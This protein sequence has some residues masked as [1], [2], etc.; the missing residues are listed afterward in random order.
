MAKPTRDPSPILATQATTP[1]TADSY[2]SAPRQHA[3]ARNTQSCTQVQSITQEAIL[4]CIHVHNDVTNHPFTAN[5]ASHRQF[6]WEILN[7]VL[8]TNTGALMEM[9]HL[10][11]SPKYKELWGK[12]YVIELGHLAQGIPGISKGT[13]TIV[14]IGQD[15]VLIN[16]RKDITYGRVCVNYHPEKADPNCTCLTVGS[17]CI[18]YPRD[19]SAPTVDM[20]MVKIHLNSIVSTK[21]ARYCTINLK[22]F[23]LNTP[24][25]RPEF[26]RMKQAELPEEFAQIYK[27]HDLANASGFVLI[28]KSKSKKE[29]MASLKQAFLHLSSSKMP[30]QAWLSPKPHHTRPMATQFLTNIL[31]TLRRQLWHQTRRPQTC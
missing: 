30:E 24:M 25:A 17:N 26:M 21:G 8:N 9:C 13:N 2:H 5:Q 7:A 6:P 22:D 29:S 3:L 11:I 14:F 12:S 19:C 18:T 23:N 4:A 27:L 28:K 31:H 1:I 20:V 16:Q 10:L 15:N